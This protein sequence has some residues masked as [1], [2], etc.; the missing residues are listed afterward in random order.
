M[1]SK[2]QGLQRE[3]NR[4]QKTNRELIAAWESLLRL[5]PEITELEK[6]APTTIA[7]VKTVINKARVTN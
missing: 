5:T 2:A 7:R 3:V 6:Q 4:L 1:A